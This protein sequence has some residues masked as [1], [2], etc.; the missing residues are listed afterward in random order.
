MS[1]GC[2]VLSCVKGLILLYLALPSNFIKDSRSAARMSS[3]F[4]PDLDSS[5]DWGGLK[6]QVLLGNFSVALSMGSKLLKV[7]LF[8]YKKVKIINMRRMNTIIKADHH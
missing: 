3:S 6:I 5:C 1:N 8:A 4:K 2:G 7:I